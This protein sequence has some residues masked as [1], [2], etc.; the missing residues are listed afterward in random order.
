MPIEAM[1]EGFAQVIAELMEQQGFKPP[2]SAAG[3]ADD[4]SIFGVHFERSDGRLEAKLV[5]QHLEIQFALPVNI[6]VVDDTNRVA[7]VLFRM[8]GERV[9]TV[10]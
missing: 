5:C 10:L 9:V 4:G 3:V 8:N 1:R 2:L 6:L 7:R